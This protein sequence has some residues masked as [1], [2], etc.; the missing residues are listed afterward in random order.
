[1]EYRDISQVNKIERLIFPD[2][3]SKE[4]FLNNLLQNKISFSFILEL[5]KRII[6][7]S[8]CWYYFNEL[9]IGNLAIHPDYQRKGLGTILLKNVFNI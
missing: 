9:H 3:W 8:V 5:N 7:Y 6:G 1:M 4:S 2:P